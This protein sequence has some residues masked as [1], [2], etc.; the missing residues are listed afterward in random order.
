MSLRDLSTE[1]MLGV[2][3]RLLNP[4]LDRP[5]LSDKYVLYSA[6]HLLKGAHEELININRQEGQVR[7]EIRELTARLTELDAEHDRCSRGIHRV[8]SGS[9]DLCDSADKAAAYQQVCETLHPTGLSVNQITY[10]EQAG[11]TLRVSRRI[12]PEIRALLDTIT[13]DGRTL[14]YWLDRWLAV[15]KKIGELQSQREMLGTDADPNYISPAAV[16][17][18]RNRWISAIHMFEISLA[19]T[20]Y[21]DTEK[22][23]ILATLRAAQQRAARARK[24]AEPAMD[25]LLDEEAPQN[26]ADE[27]TTGSVIEGNANGPVQDDAPAESVEF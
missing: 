12:T 11:N 8:L 22:A 3:E 23:S 7:T 13:V 2:S 1:A 6:L 24:K 5:Q 4:P 20:D 19:A 17:A 27:A 14:N 10:L 18:A 21:T 25:A 26:G 16:L 15:G 9:L